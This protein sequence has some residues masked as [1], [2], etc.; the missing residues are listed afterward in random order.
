MKRFIRYLAGLA[1]LL[2]LV[3]AGLFTQLWFSAITPARV[4]GVRQ[5]Q[6]DDDGQ[7]ALSMVLVYPAT[8]KATRAWVGSGFM[9]Y[10][11][12]APIDGTA[13]P[14]IVMSHGTGGGPTGHLDTA[15]ALAEAG[16]IV[17]AVTHRGDNFQDDRLV[18]KANWITERAR[19][20]S[21]ATDFLLQTW[22]EH[23]RIDQKRVGVFGFS[24]GATTALVS[25]GGVLDMGAIAPHCKAQ[26]EFV[27]SLFRDIETL[28]SPEAP[29]PKAHPRFAAA[30][31]VAPGLGFGFRPEGLGAVRVPV[32]LWQA[33]GDE[34]VPEASN[35]EVVRSLL[36]TA[37]EYQVVPN[38]SHLS[39]LAPCSMLASIM[40]PRMLC[41]DPEGFDRAAFHREFNAQVITFFDRE[42]DVATPPAMPPAS[43]N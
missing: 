29:E 15:I 19:Q 42:L 3:A 32:Q 18:G 43:S 24:A 28:K 8:G 17:A 30:V 12:T 11:R 20:I 27:C 36:P 9:D 38:A 10:A 34:R 13:L 6:V 35:A 7:A 1:A 4:I 31:V 22:P 2:A 23:E 16:Y 14:M 33:Q 26:P 21:L 40:L 37:P 39:F 5:L 25:V 41:S